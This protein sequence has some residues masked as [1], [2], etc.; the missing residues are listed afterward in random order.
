MNPVSLPKNYYPPII[1]ARKFSHLLNN[2]AFLCGL[3]Y[4]FS[5]T[6]IY[7]IISRDQKLKSNVI[8]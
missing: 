2:Q 1:P 8:N 5:I 6:P 4:N 3:R 7:Q